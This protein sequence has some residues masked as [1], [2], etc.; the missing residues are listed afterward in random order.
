MCDLFDDWPVQRLSQKR[1]FSCL[2]GQRCCCSVLPVICLHLL[3]GTAVFFFLPSSNHT[4][5]VFSYWFRL[6]NGKAVCFEKKCTM[7]CSFNAW[8]AEQCS[9]TRDAVNVFS[10]V[11]SGC[12]PFCGDEHFRFVQVCAALPA[13]H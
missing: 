2:Q 11:P 13:A 4:T 3:V 1:A 9:G 5:R 10:N 7:S 12:I 8:A 6:A